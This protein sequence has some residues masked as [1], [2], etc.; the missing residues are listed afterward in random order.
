MR[1]RRS[2]SACWRSSRR[3]RQSQRL[4]RRSW[5]SAQRLGDR[6]R[7]P[8]GERV[9][10]TAA[11]VPRAP[12]STR[13]A[14]L[15]RSAPPTSSSSTGELIRDDQAGGRRQP[16]TTYVLVGQ[17]SRRGLLES[18]AGAVAGSSD[19]GA[20]RHR[21]PDGRRPDEAPLGSGGGGA[22]EL[23]PPLDVP[24]PHPPRPRRRPPRRSA[25]PPGGRPLE[26][27]AAADPLPVHWLEPLSTGA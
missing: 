20:A 11:K 21:H 12:S 10:P 2:V 23:P 26:A 7:C 4:V 18:L 25:P 6:A 27:G 9:A 3:G 19:R 15:P 17:P 1:R 22:A 13:S 24:R 16:G 14:G 8:L 5:R